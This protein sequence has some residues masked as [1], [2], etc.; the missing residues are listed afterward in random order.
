MDR[1]LRIQERKAKLMGLDTGEKV[2]PDEMPTDRDQLIKELREGIR[3]LKQSRKP[4]LSS[5]N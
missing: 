4:P 2:A 1:V 3:A 5:E